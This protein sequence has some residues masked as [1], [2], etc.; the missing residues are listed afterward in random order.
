MGF[1]RSWWDHDDEP[2]A[3]ETA[4]PDRHRPGAAGL[5]AGAR[6]VVAA[7]RLP[8][9]YTFSESAAAGGLIAYSFDLKDLNRQV[10]KDIDAFLKRASLAD[11]PFCQVARLILS[12]NLKTARALRLDLAPALV[13]RADD[14]ID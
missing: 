5:V 2:S 14:V 7:S 10:A 6:P 1:R 4:G 8:A 9:I 13:A 12:V 3:H 11:I